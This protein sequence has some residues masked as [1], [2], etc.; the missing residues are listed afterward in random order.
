[1]KKNAI[2]LSL[3]ITPLT[4]P[5][6][7]LSISQLPP[8]GSIVTQTNRPPVMYGFAA[9]GE[10]L[11]F[12]RL[13]WGLYPLLPLTEKD[14]SAITLTDERNRVVMHGAPAR[15]TNAAELQFVFEPKQLTVQSGRA[16]TLSLTPELKAGAPG[17]FVVIKLEEVVAISDATKTVLGHIGGNDLHLA[18]RFP[19][20]RLLL[21]IAESR[22]SGGRGAELVL[23]WSA[24]RNTLYRIEESTDLTNWRTV[25]DARP[26]AD[27]EIRFTVSVNQFQP[28]RFFRLAATP[29]GETSGASSPPAQTPPAAQ[30]S[31]RS[32]LPFFSFGRR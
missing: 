16:Q 3:L 12:T 32:S 6:Q 9:A 10:N 22:T 19:E 2:A 1:M 8:N 24:E 15:T 25:G 17:G 29:K 18:V 20:G 13:R 23:R 31:P 21:A 27:G 5:A 26:P 7:T 11:T 28:H 14:V 30:E 4:L